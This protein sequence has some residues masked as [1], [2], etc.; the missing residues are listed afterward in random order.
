MTEFISTTG[1]SRPT[2]LPEPPRHA[3]R[4]AALRAAA[5]S[6]ATPTRSASSL[7]AAA[8]QLL[9]GLTGRR[10]PR[11]GGVRERLQAAEAG[12]D[13]RELDRA[14]HALQEASAAV[15]FLPARGRDFPV[16]EFHRQAAAVVAAA[17]RLA[18]GSLH[19]VGR[20]AA[21]STATRLL[22]A[23]L[24]ME[25]RSIDKRVRQGLLWLGDMEQE[26]ATR[27]ASATAEVSRRAL[28]ELG[29][30]GE[31]LAGELHVVQGL[32]GAVRA[33]R[34]L[35]DQVQ[36]HR[37]GLCHLL[38]E[39]VRPASLKLQQRLQALLDAAVARAPEPA[40]RLA[41][42]EGRHD[43]DVALTRAGAELQQLQS[44]QTELAA[45]LARVAEAQPLA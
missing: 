44:L 33:A 13:L 21:E 1:R 43:L 31:A 34:S 38:Q 16:A 14:L 12:W 23:E 17:Q 6:I 22:W 39:E 28:E 37:T 40:E 7:A 27:R 36:A 11:L 25:G 42:V 24:V 20:H 15:D 45:Q 2:A 10:V 18:T 19:L 32:C 41:A 30:R 3:S 35:G 26:L 8:H 9:Q 29:R 4:T 5:R